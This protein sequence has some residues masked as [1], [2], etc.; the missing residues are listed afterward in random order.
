MHRTIRLFTVFL[1]V[2]FSSYSVAESPDTPWYEFEVIVFLNNSSVAGQSEAWRDS[3]LP[4]NL[5]VSIDP[6]ERQS[7]ASGIGNMQVPVHELL[8]ASQYQLTEEYSRLDRSSR[9]TPLIH[10]GWRQPVQSDDTARSI[11][12][13]TNEPLQGGSMTYPGLQQDRETALHRLDGTIRLSINRYLHADVDLYLRGPGYL[14]QAAD[15]NSTTRAIRYFNL[16]ESRRIK[17]N[18]VHYFDHPL[19]GLLLS[20]RPYTRPDDVSLPQ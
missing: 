7:T 13:H 15:H 19:L 1:T 16:N 2:V 3:P 18:E 4:E 14:Q 20:A 12:L 11:R 6:H 8:P 17:S 5:S 9:Y 10:L